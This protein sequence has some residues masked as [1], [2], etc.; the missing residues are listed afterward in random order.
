MSKHARFIVLSL[1]LA[2][3]AAPPPRSGQPPVPGGV[4][5]PGSWES[6]PSGPGPSRPGTSIYRV[7]AQ[8]SEIRL[9][10][11]RAGALANLGHNHVIALHPSRGWVAVA[12]PLSD[13]RLR[14]EVPVASALVDDAS[15]RRQEG[16]D[17][18][19]DIDE[20]AKSGTLHNM[21]SEALLDAARFP[22]LAVRS[23][24]VS[25]GGS[26]IALRLRFTVAGR[27]TLID[28]PVKFERN[29][30]GITAS[31]QF[32]LKQSALGLTPF[33]IMLGALQ[34]QDQMSVKFRIVAGR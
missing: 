22:V 30:A 21:L 2:S 29:G 20:S 8:S 4:A 5:A 26:A 9:L 13:S 23:E 10:V 14:L 31:G 19:G 3:C 7:D 34:V 27:D 6:G 11:Y 12:A 15:M 33:S 18:P 25:G 1:L 16:A 24:S 32:N 17:F 28:V